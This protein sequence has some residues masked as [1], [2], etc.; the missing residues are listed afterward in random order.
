MWEDK[1]WIYS[2]FFFFFFL[3]AA[4]RASLRCFQEEIVPFLL[5]KAG[6]AG[7]RG[8]PLAFLIFQYSNRL[9]TAQTPK[10]EN[11]EGVDKNFP[12]LA[13]KWYS[14][15]NKT[16]S[17]FLWK[18][19]RSGVPINREKISQIIAMLICL[20]PSRKVRNRLKRGVK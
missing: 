13:L 6:A 14:I 17:N 5:T 3:A 9:C 8:K 2:G 16:V 10:V 20:L 15:L 19:K 1:V 18:V 12:Y 11:E 4:L 7:K